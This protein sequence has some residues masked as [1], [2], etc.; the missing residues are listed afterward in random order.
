MTHPHRRD[1]QIRRGKIR[2]LQL[3]ATG[4]ALYC[5]IRHD[6]TSLAIPGYLLVVIVGCAVDRLER[7][8]AVLGRRITD[9]ERHHG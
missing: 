5:A 3:L 2:A 6:I 1:D 7:I 4:L 8:I 9:R